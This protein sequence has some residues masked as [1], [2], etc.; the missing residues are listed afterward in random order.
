[1]PSLSVPPIEL[2]TQRAMRAMRETF[3]YLPLAPRK[4]NVAVAGT[5]GSLVGGEAATGKA[6]TLPPRRIPDMTED[7]I[8]L[9]WLLSSRNSSPAGRRSIWILFKTQLPP[10]VP[11]KRK[12]RERERPSK[13]GRIIRKGKRRIQERC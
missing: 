2:L 8:L 9:A 1:M 7:D 5:I 11:V 4:G 12:R 10:P 6:G 13:E 3:P